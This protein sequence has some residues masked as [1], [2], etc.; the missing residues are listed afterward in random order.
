M[1]INRFPLAALAA[2]AVILPCTTVSG[3]L[4]PTVRASVDSLIRVA[5]PDSGPGG[6]VLVARG[7]RVLYE[8]AFG[9]ANLEL[10]V[11]MRPDAVFRVASITKQF[12]S[13]AVLQ[14]V[15]RGVLS[16]AD[17]VGRFAPALSPAL[18]SLTVEQL[19]THT[20]GVPNA[21]TIAPLL[22]A[23]R[24]W[25]TADQVLGT[26]R[27]QPLAFEPGSRFEYS[28]SGYQLLGYVVEQVTKEPYPEYLE[29]TVLRAAGMT[30]SLWGNDMRVVQGRPASY[31]FVRDRIENAVNPNVQVAWAA[32]AI[33]STA[34]DLHRWYRA[35]AR[36]TLVS[37]SMLARAWT[38]GLTRDGAATDYGF[39][40][41]VGRLAGERIV[42]H[43]GN[44]GGFM[45]HAIYAPDQE[46]LVVIL[47]NSRGRRLPEL[48][49]TEIM[50]SELGAPLALRAVPL[51]AEQL[52]T[53]VGVYRDGQGGRVQLRVENGKLLY[54]RTGA[55]PMQMIPSAIDRFYFDNTSIVAE[56]KRDTTGL[57]V[58]LELQ[59]LRGQDRKRLDREPGA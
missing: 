21:K 11:P 17:T 54:Q 50:A 30:R 48:L 6:V 39:G 43:G 47:L 34:R 2:V 22:A 59:T 13:I 53:Y 26:F 41:F 9:M 45:S 56:A 35:L 52:G 49:A 3:Q 28:N 46:L 44:M 24:G 42:E 37:D 57:V 7:D 58:R 27:D 32:G 18:R 31:L 14:L 1:S 36:G 25:L 38:P 33:E 15:E 12:T 8:R 5:Y 40:W 55:S 23:G 4:R 20:A 19:L 10:G 51:T 16:L 29:R